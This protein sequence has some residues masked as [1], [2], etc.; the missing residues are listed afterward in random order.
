MKNSPSGK[1]TCSKAQRDTLERKIDI[2]NQVCSK[3]FLKDAA[4]SIT[5]FEANT[6]HMVFVFS[7][8]I[9]DL[10]NYSVHEDIGRRTRWLTASPQRLSFHCFIHWL[11]VCW[12]SSLYYFICSTVRQHISVSYDTYA[13]PLVAVYSKYTMFIMSFNVLSIK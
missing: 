5:P 10:G 9:I 11:F 12:F 1:W 4:V 8:L 7:R 3:S 2:T 6:E 13:N